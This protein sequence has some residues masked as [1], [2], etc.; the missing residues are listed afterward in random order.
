MWYC[1]NNLECR[2]R[3]EE[4]KEVQIGEILNSMIITYIKR[5]TQGNEKFL[6][7]RGMKNSFAS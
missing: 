4:E 7:L 1:F 5:R 3:S 2:E 6:W